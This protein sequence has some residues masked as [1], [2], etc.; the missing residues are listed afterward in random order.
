M[1]KFVYL[2]ALMEG[3]LSISTE[4]MAIRRFS[5]YFGA[6]LPET[7]IIIGIFL[8]FLSLGYSSSEKIKT[9]PPK[10]L[11]RNFLLI[12]IFYIFTF[13]HLFND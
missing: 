12:L 5:P 2:I 7:S 6:A 11:R 13:Q 1:M 8:L 4:I 10:L 3:Y 9:S